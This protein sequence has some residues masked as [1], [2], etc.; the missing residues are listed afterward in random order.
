MRDIVDDERRRRSVRNRHQ[1]FGLRGRSH[2]CRGSLGVCA[3]EEKGS[4]GR[5]ALIVFK[6]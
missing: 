6:R 1:P 5:G 4:L 2:L 3:A